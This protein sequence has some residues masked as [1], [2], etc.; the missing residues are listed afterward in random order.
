MKEAEANK[1]INPALREQKETISR[2]LQDAL[3]LNVGAKIVVRNKA[4]GHWQL[5]IPLGQDIPT[6]EAIVAGER[7][8]IAFDKI[9]PKG[10]LALLETGFRQKMNGAVGGK[11]LLEAERFIKTRGVLIRLVSGNIG[12]R[13]VV[14]PLQKER[15]E[16]I[17][18][19]LNEEQKQ[20]YREARRDSSG[21][22]F[23]DLIYR[24]ASPEAREQI[25]Q[26]AQEALEEQKRLEQIK[27]GR[28]KID[29]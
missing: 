7:I 16:I 10:F 9:H 13:S 26:R 5:V 14:K 2:I 25:D 22:I 15:R 4:T 24:N 18:E 3:A 29:L 17:K 28:G 11:E 27:R 12:R 19:N 1:K 23:L 6:L 8:E 21:Q 20:E